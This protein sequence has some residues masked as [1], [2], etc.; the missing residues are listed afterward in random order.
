MIAAQTMQAMLPQLRVYTSPENYNSEIGLCLSILWL[1]KRSQQLA[2][3]IALQALWIG[4]FGRKKYDVLVAEYGLDAKKDIEYLLTIA[5]PHV[6]I[7]TTAGLVHAQGVWGPDEII[8]EKSKLLTWASEIALLSAGS[9]S[10]MDAYLK[11]YEK[12]IL[13]YALHE[14]DAES[15]DIWFRNWL[16]L[17]N[18]A[19]LP[20]S[21]FTIE[22]GVESIVT[23]ETNLLSMVDAWY[24]C[25]SVELAMIIGKRL[26][27]QI[28]PTPDQLQFATKQGRLSL[29]NGKWGST[30]VDSTYNASPKSMSHAIQTTVKL[31]NEL[32][33]WHNL[34]YC[35]GDMRELGEYEEKEHRVLASLVAQSADKLYVVWPAMHTY[36]ADELNKIWYN[37]DDVV[38]ASSSEALWTILD[39]D[40]PTLEKRSVVLFKWSQNTIFMEEAIKPLLKNNNDKKNLVRQSWSWKHKK[41]KYFAS[42]LTAFACLLLAWCTPAQIEQIQTET[43]TVCIEK[44]CYDVELS[45]TPAQR[46]QWLMHRE[47][48]ADDAGML[49]VFQQPWSHN[50]WMKNT[51]IPLDMLWIDASWTIVHIEENVQPC[52]LPDWQRCPS[53]G[54]AAWTEAMYVLE[55]NAGESEEY[56]FEVWD[57]LSLVNITDNDY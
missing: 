55:V 28:L 3:F 29:Y 39:T 50:F 20:V 47:S 32:Y 9:M 25:L 16:L 54:P 13:T 5:V 23:M 10:Y 49:F 7:F 35:L 2:P 12:D 18:D 40:L 38:L 1:E 57:V 34:I 11:N 8:A 51:L 46:S 22:Q 26:N 36:L 14:G 21:R 17:Q 42:I 37:P 33:P 41:K 43:P 24:V 6:G 45:T 52:K 53:Y 4:L 31:R 27:T 19:W 30:L 48:L 15:A 56:E 44:T